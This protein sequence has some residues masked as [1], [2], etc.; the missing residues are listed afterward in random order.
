ME[1]ERNTNDNFTD[2]SNVEFSHCTE[3]ITNKLI[4]ATQKSNKTSVLIRAYGKNSEVLIDRQQELIVGIEI[5]YTLNFN[6]L[7]ILN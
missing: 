3:G 1:K 4:K 2:T 5:L 6:F 7:E